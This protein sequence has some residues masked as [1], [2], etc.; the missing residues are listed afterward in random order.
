MAFEIDYTSL[1]P[2]LKPYLEK[3]TNKKLHNMQF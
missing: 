1:N 3:N 2:C